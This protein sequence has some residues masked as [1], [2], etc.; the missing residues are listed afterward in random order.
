MSV[1]PVLKHRS[2]VCAVDF[3]LSRIAALFPSKKQM[4][5]ENSGPLFSLCYW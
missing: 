3:Y 1:F 2:V 5:K 4:R